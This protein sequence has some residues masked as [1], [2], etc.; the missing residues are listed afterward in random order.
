MQETV[1]KATVTSEIMQPIVSPVLYISSGHDNSCDNDKSQNVT[2]QLYFVIYTA[3]LVSWYN[4][5][6][7]DQL[8]IAPANS[9]RLMLQKISLHHQS[10][11]FSFYFILNFTL[12]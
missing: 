3:Q 1:K 8:R 2:K 7:L 6:N 5:T 9:T 10:I 12:F 11:L 4:Y